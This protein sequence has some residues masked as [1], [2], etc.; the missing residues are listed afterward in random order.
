MMCS[1]SRYV[2]VAWFA[3]LF[4]TTATGSD[5]LGWLAAGLTVAA[6]YAFARLF[7]ARFGGGSCALP[8]SWAR[9]TVGDATT[10]PAEP[11]PSER[12]HG[13]AHG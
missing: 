2:L 1:A 11:R 4:A 10:A 6:T 7:P 12:G 8:Q 3:G 13:P 9:D 5:T